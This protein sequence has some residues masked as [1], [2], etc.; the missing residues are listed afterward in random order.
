M[1]RGMAGVRR[2]GWRRACDRRPMTTRGR[3]GVAGVQAA[4]GTFRGTH[5]RRVQGL[6][7]GAR[8]NRRR[9]ASAFVYGGMVACRRGR[10]WPYARRRARGT[11]P[12][13]QFS[14]ALFDHLLLKISKQKWSKR[15]IAKL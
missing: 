10:A 8:P 5:T 6:G 11:L 7:R 13:L 3:H 12:A 4:R 2:T 9:R 14:I 1:G 15:S